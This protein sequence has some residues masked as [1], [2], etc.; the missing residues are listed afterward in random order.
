LDLTIPAQIFAS[1][2]LT[3]FVY[4]LV[5]VGLTLIFSLMRLVN[6]AHGEFLMLS[7]YFAYWANVV[8]G[9]DPLL[10]LPVNVVLMFGLGAAYYRLVVRRIIHAPAINQ[11]FTTFG[12]IVLLQGTA[13]LLWTPDYR[14]VADPVASGQLSIVGV[15]LSVPQLVA[16]LGAL[17]GFVAL[18]LFMSRTTSGKAMR[19]TSQDRPAAALVGIDTDRM[20]MFGVS[21]GMAALAIAGTL[22]MNFVPVY[23]LVGVPFVLVSFVIVALGG[24]GSITGAFIAALLIGV[25]ESVAGFVLDSAYKQAIVYALFL[26]VAIFRPQGLLGRY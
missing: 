5:A 12:L 9:I 25:A 19:A 22:L 23:P 14:T 13:Q 7:M 6:F 24:F 10:F 17:L 15:Y 26:V 2:L 1:G 8:L 18:Y 16:G 20:F 21:F 3:G 11:I 4:A